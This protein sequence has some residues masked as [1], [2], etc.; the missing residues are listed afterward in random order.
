MERTRINNIVFCIFCGTIISDSQISRRR[1][2]AG[3]SQCTRWINFYHCDKCGKS[4][5]YKR[6]QTHKKLFKNTLFELK[7]QQC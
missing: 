2:E 3:P 4:F 7:K 6:L 1:R 5:D